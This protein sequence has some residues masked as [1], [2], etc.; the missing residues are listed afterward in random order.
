MGIGRLGFSGH[1]RALGAWAVRQPAERRPATLRGPPVTPR[2]AATEVCDSAEEDRIVASLKQAVHDHLAADPEV[3]GLVA[4]RIYPVVLPSTPTLPALT[5]SGVSDAPERDLNGV[6]RRRAQLLLTCWG[7]T[8]DSATQVAAAVR[9]ALQDYTGQIGI[10]GPEILDCMVTDLL[11]GFDDQTG[12]YR[13]QVDAR[14][15]FRGGF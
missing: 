15:L 1:S 13:V 14:I 3:S 6:V 12:I 9:S 7:S 11:D 10:D 8:Y 4:G 2:L 5:Y